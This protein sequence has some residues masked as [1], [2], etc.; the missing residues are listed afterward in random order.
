[1]SETPNP[2]VNEETP[3]V[4]ESHSEQQNTVQVQNEPPAQNEKDQSPPL[5]PDYDPFENESPSDVI[6]ASEAVPPFTNESGE[7]LFEVVWGMV[8]TGNGIFY[9]GDIQPESAFGD[10]LNAKI[11]EGSIK[12]FDI[13]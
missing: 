1:M 9:Q 4:Q 7:T 11:D 6:D 12:L 8:S 3:P 2:P 13:E 5:P 10:L